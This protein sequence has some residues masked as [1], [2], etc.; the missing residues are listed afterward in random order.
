MLQGEPIQLVKVKTALP[1]LPYPPLDQRQSIMTERLLIRPWSQDDLQNIHELR[2][3]PEVMQWS[4]RGKVDENLEA[5]KRYFDGHFVPDGPTG[6]RSH[7][8]I[9]CLN[10]TGEFIG[11]GGSHRR[12]GSLGWPELG[13]TIKREYWG[14]GYATEFV[15]AYLAFW[16]S[17]PRAELEMEVDKATVQEDARTG[18][19]KENIVAITTVHN[20]ASRNVMRK[21]GFK[22]TKLWREQD[23]RDPTQMID[24]YCHTVQKD[25]STQPLQ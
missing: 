1:A 10:S 23:L 12:E 14:K 2:T 25:T 16:W 8:M 11:T 17:L 9:I 18:L 20:E 7:D 15:Q 19:V 4:A 22:L 5:T 24:L 3:Q 6:L 21:A 13:Y